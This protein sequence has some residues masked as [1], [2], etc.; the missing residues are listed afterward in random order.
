MK[1]LLLS[2]IL[3]VFSIA[4]IGCTYSDDEV[5][6]ENIE[7]TLDEDVILEESI[8]YLELIDA[9]LELQE[10]LH[11]LDEM[12]RSLVTSIQNVSNVEELN[13]Y[14]AQFEECIY[15]RNQYLQ[16]FYDLLLLPSE[17]VD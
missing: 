13:T 7:D 16:T 3:F 17:E 8:R 2:I 4:M 9:F 11:N 5:E 14:L 1:K 12:E 10:N 6:N 15:L